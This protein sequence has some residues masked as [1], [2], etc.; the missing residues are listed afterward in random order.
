MSLTDHPA[1]P[2]EDAARHFEQL[3]QFETDCWDVHA[4]LEANETGFVLLDVRSPEL[5]SADALRRSLL[6][7]GGGT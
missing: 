3:L 1:A 6:R 5:Y 2:S 4:S 7:P